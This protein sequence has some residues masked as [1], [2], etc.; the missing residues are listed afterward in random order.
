MGKFYTILGLSIWYIG[1]AFEKISFKIKKIS[2]KLN[3]LS[4]QAF[5][6]NYNG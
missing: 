2:H 6:R 5:W 4:I 3:D 1:D